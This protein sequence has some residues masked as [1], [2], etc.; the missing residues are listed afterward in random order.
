MKILIVTALKLEYNAVAAFLDDNSACRKQ[1]PFSKSYYTVYTYHQNN[2][3]CEI[4]L[5]LAGEGNLNA[6]GET[7]QALAYFKSVDYT[8]FVGVAGGLKSKDL[9]LGDVVVSSGV[10]YYEMSKIEREDVKYRSV[11]FSISHELVKTANC[12]S[13]EQTGR[14][15]WHARLPEGDMP[16]SFIKLIAAGEKVVADM[17]SEIYQYLSNY[18]NNAFA[19]E[20][21]GAGFLRAAEDYEVRGIVV[22]GISD[23]I[24]NKEESDS[25]G[26]Q[27]IAARN[28]AAFAFRMIDLLIESNKNLLL[29][30][31]PGSVQ[32]SDLLGNRSTDNFYEDIYFKRNCDFELYKKIEQA[33]YRNLSVSRNAPK[34]A[35]TGHSLAGK[36]RM[37]FELIHQELKDNFLIHICDNEDTLESLPSFGYDEEHVYMIVID[38]IN[39][40]SSQ[41]LNRFLKR[42]NHQVCI[43]ATCSTLEWENLDCSVRNF[44][45]G[46]EIPIDTLS[47]LEIEN[48]VYKFKLKGIYKKHKS[49][50]TI[51]GILFNINDLRQKCERLNRENAEVRFLFSLIYY[52]SIWKGRN[53]GNL[54]LMSEFAK[55][56]DDMASYEKLY[57][58]A[59]LLSKEKILTIREEVPLCGKTIRHLDVD[60][61]IV[62]EILSDF[63]YEK[64][65]YTTKSKVDTG[66]NRKADLEFVKQIGQED[67]VR[68]RTESWYINL[69]LNAETS[70]EVLTKVFWRVKF[71]ETKKYIVSLFPFTTLKQENKTSS[72]VNDASLHWVSVL[73]EK[74]WIKET[75][76]ETELDFHRRFI[77]GGIFFA[78]SF[79]SAMAIYIKAQ[80]SN[81]SDI[82]Q[83]GTLISK[84]ETPEQMSLVD[85]MMK[86]MDVENTYELSTLCFLYTKCVQVA[87]VFEQAF[88]YLPKLKGCFEL[89]KNALP[90]ESDE[91]E[92]AGNLE[93]QLFKFFCAL[94]MKVTTMAQLK[95]TQSFIKNDFSFPGFK[96]PGNTEIFDQLPVYTHQAMIAHFD[97]KQ[98][99]ELLEFHKDHITDTE[100]KNF[101]ENHYIFTVDSY[102]EALDI[103]SR[104]SVRNAF[105]YSMLLK[106]TDC[107]FDSA[108]ELFIQNFV[109]GDLI[110][111]PLV[112]NELIRKSPNATEAVWVMSLFTKYDIAYDRYT[113]NAILDFPWV[114][115][116][117]AKQLIAE[118]NWYSLLDE[119]SL[120]ILIKKELTFE[121]AYAYFD[122]SKKN[123][124]KQK[125][126]TELLGLLQNN[127][128]SQLSL[129]EKEIVRDD[130]E[131]LKIRFNHLQKNFKDSG[132]MNELYGHY[133]ANKS[134]IASYDEAY[135]FLKACGVDSTKYDKFIFG[136]LIKLLL[137]EYKEVRDCVSVS[138]YAGSDTEKKAEIHLHKLN[139]L[140]RSLTDK[141][142]CQ[143]ATS[144]RLSFFY[145]MDDRQECL[146][147]ENKSSER[148]YT[149]RICTCKE[150]IKE[151]ISRGYKVNDYT[152]GKLVNK[153]DGNSREHLQFLLSCLKES[154]YRLNNKLYEKIK[155]YFESVFQT[156]PSMMEVLTSYWN[157]K[158]DNKYF[159]HLLSISKS[160]KDVYEMVKREKKDHLLPLTFWNIVL[161]KMSE[162]KAGMRTFKEGLHVF[163]T[164]IQDEYS[165]SDY[166]FSSLFALANT[167]EEMSEVFALFQAYNNKIGKKRAIQMNQQ[168]YTSCIRCAPVLDL[169]ISYIKEAREQNL[170]LTPHMFNALLDKYVGEVKIGRSDYMPLLM[171]FC[172]TLVNHNLLD[173]GLLLQEETSVF[174]IP[175]RYTYNCLMRLPACTDAVWEAMQKCGIVPDAHSFLIRIGVIPIQSPQAFEK[176][177]TVAEQ[178]RKQGFLNRDLFVVLTQRANS[179]VHFSEVFTLFAE[180]KPREIRDKEDVKNQQV[181]RELKVLLARFRLDCNRTKPRIVLAISRLITN[182]LQ[183]LPSNFRHE[184]C[185]QY[186]DRLVRLSILCRKSH[187]SDFYFE[188]LRSLCENIKTVGSA[189][190]ENCLSGL[191]FE[192]RNDVKKILYKHMACRPLLSH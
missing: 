62:E 57:N 59:C 138:D 55:R 77:S 68:L 181:I 126:P 91:E 24:C 136:N 111:N 73:R 35:I 83:F 116:Q 16:N 100:K 34:I 53:K 118:H 14:Q 49:N 22:R 187:V 11:P 30:R 78:D 74:L 131:K 43:I 133:I 88:A 135:A 157:K 84:V 92:N 80:E 18:H 145:S 121:D 165:L 128:V 188:T 163:K 13:L 56:I 85:G 151:T 1:N 176:A 99:M 36:S 179:V 81:L 101:L 75:A 2:Y 33:E 182:N 48:Y 173:C 169:A 12:V 50:K 7:S 52:F 132:R 97:P 41:K 8:F 54:S 155:L 17:E 5:I 117:K 65:A 47:S 142:F 134:L 178:S 152:I 15:L 60:E 69:I 106:K 6:V 141:L 148:R 161:K 123:E 143:A 137:A 159:I 28:A 164:Y 64:M 175:D 21:E 58:A 66:K 72:N 39:N 3:A 146:F 4:I 70:F 162:E 26:Y 172:E 167:N 51:G 177:K 20:M 158:M 86:E 149:S 170:S 76:N 122:S 46:N 19:V 108:K 61:F 119:H 63:Q 105:T 130:L 87:C 150:Y 38:D 127:F 139:Q 94:F 192:E 120:G 110:V 79:K 180:V 37:V 44:F 154:R 184:Y 183:C 112:L 153:S 96:N 174:I 103:Y 93:N 32:P 109:N 42:I 171:N 113:I 29:F 104:I 45:A 156:D 31:P 129:F 67:K 114:S 23:M 95:Q 90:D 115:V 191:T 168:M 107:Q 40:F 71:V 185:M 147:K 98:K 10:V 166:T 140:L 190:L 9:K 82:F 89:Q 160:Y 144:D 189:R 25:S 102:E 124:F 186:T 27:P 125:L